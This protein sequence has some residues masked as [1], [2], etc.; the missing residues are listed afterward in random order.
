MS[1]HIPVVLRLVHLNT[2]IIAPCALYLATC[3]ANQRKSNHKRLWWNKDCKII[4]WT[5]YSEKPPFSSISSFQS[6][7]HVWDSLQLHGL[8]HAKP[9]C[10]SPTPGVYSN[11]CPLSRWCHP[12]FPI[13]RVFSNEFFASSGQSIGVSAS[14]SALPMNVQ[15]WFPL[16]RTGW[17]SLQSR[18]FSKSSLTPQFK[19]IKSLALSFIYSP[20]FTS[21]HD[22]WKNHS[23]D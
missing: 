22:Y 19:S 7:S 15:D 6:L 2:W 17:I 11:S 1:F 4:L 20:T 21:I 12:I 14:G 13:I 3:E 10:P 8:Q 5:N 9:P 23:F 16:G 18:G